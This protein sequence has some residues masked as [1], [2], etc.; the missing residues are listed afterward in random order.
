MEKVEIDKNLC[1]GCGAC[2]AICP[3]NFEI[4]DD[5]LA[6]VTN[7]K[8]TDEVKEA[9]ENCPTDAIKIKKTDKKEEL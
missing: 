8:V 6:E 7:D 4:G 9:A 2:A 5:G 3:K 1:I